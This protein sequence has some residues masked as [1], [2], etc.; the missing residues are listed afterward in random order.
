M[1]R[2]LTDSP[3]RAA[4]ARRFGE[5]GGLLRVRR[6]DDH[7][8]DHDSEEECGGHGHLHG[9]H[10]DCDEG[11]ETPEDDELTCVPVP[12]EETTG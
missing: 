5:H 7:D 3:H 9:N 6:N 10:C 11:Y 4:I 2:R 1:K 8:H 12:A